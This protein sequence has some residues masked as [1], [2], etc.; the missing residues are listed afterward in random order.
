MPNISSVKA[1]INGQEY[2]LT[3][4]GTSGKYEATITAP[5]QSSYTKDGHYY[6]ISLTAA[7]TAGNSTTVNETDA[8]LG[9]SLKLVV[10]EKVA[11]TIKI[12]SPSAGATIINNKPS[13]VVE[14][15]DNDSGVNESTF[16]LTVG[17]LAAHA[18]DCSVESI[19]GGKRFTYTPTTAL[20]DGKQTITVN[21]SDNDGNAATA[22]TATVTVDTTPP[23]LNVTSPANDTWQ[24]AYAA[25]VVGTTNDE[26]SSPVTVNITVNGTDAGAVTVGEGGAFSKEITLTEGDNTIVI[27]ATD[28]AG[29]SSSVTRTVH[30][31]TTAPVFKAV[32]VTPNPVDA[33]Q[34]YIISVEIE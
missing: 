31:N 21:A 22:A 19:T 9:D 25:T 17:S 24:N 30:V 18:S 16:T 1:T 20:S 26:T 32:T 14:V 28:A 11:P 4:N 10:K 3:Y 15:T 8:V 2:T 13:I 5:A 29:K 27:T 23:V 33:G 7:D 12:V 6:G 34:T